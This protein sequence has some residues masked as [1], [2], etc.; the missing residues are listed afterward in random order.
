MVLGLSPNFISNEIKESRVC[1]ASY[2][3]ITLSL[4]N[5]SV[6]IFFYEL[7][8]DLDK[9]SC[10]P[11]GPRGFVRF[12]YLYSLLNFLSGDRHCEILV[13]MVGNKVWD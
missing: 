2:F 10:E 9:P 11:V 1:T 5:H 13:L 7:P 4:Q 12:H 3:S 8:T 6:E